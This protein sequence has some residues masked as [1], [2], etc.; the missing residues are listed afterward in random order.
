MA[1]LEAYATTI[2]TRY[3]GHLGRIYVSELAKRKSQPPKR[4]SAAARAAAG[5]APATA[6]AR[7]SLLASE[8]RSPGEV[9]EDKAAMELVERL[10]DERVEIEGLLNAEPEEVDEEAALA[11]AM[12]LVGRHREIETEIQVLMTELERRRARRELAAKSVSSASSTSSTSASLPG[13]KKWNVPSSRP[14]YRNRVSFSATVA[15]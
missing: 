8:R 3:R 4:P 11:T 1:S 2:Q 13:S 6:A 12:Q 15:S 14:G 9:E 5:V 10:F 7:A